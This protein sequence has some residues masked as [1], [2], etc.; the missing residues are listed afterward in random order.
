MVVATAA[1]VA[2]TAAAVVTAAVVAATAAAAAAARAAAVAG[3]A[4][5]PRNTSTIAPR[6]VCGGRANVAW[7]GPSR[8]GPFCRASGRCIPLTREPLDLWHRI[9]L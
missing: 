4:T 3:A 9:G 5:R 1:A 2:A 8:E 6:Q 7:N